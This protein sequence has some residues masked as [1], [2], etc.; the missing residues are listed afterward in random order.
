MK[1]DMISLSKSMLINTL[2]NRALDAFISAAECFSDVIV[3]HMSEEDEFSDTACEKIKNELEII[4]SSSNC[5]D[6]MDCIIKLDD[7]SEFNLNT[8]THFDA[9]LLKTLFGTPKEF[10]KF[11]SKAICNA[12]TL[13]PPQA[14]EDDISSMIDSLI[15]E[16]KQ[17]SPDSNEES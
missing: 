9:T 13:F 4:S 7:K 6:F 11:F 10:S 15:E 17:N 1:D 3:A 2:A 16:S 8:V 5:S 14:L 12:H